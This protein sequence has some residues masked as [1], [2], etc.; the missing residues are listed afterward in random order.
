MA[1]FWSI[2]THNNSCA[3]PNDFITTT[4]SIIIGGSFFLLALINLIAHILLAL[5]IYKD[6]KTIFQKFFVYRL[7]LSM[8]FMAILNMLVHF[9]MTI[10]C[11]LTGC[12]NW[13][14]WLLQFLTSFYRTM[15]YGFLLAVMLIAMDRFFCFYF[16][17]FGL[18]FFQKV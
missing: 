17:H 4:R 11:T 2:H 7:I 9:M 1:D 12:P 3:R 8:S 16:Q 5:T 14:I 13:P 18:I 6:W 10:P 15:E